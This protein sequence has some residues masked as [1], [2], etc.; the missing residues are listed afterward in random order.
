M[1]YLK[2]KVIN[3]ERVRKV[4]R[5]FSWVDRKFM[6]EGYL[7]QLGP[8]AIILYFFLVIVGDPQGLSFYGEQR[9]GE[10]LHM[11]SQDLERGRHQLIIQN[12]IAYQ[13]PLYQVLSLGVEERELSAL[14]EN[15][16]KLIKEIMDAT[17]KQFL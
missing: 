14:G 9:I 16:P 17:L 6:R 3:P 11:N 12:L 8:E 15:G 2:K 13:K 1:S 10:T 5:S 4:P 7:Q